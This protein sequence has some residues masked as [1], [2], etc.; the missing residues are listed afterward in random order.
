V[1]LSDIQGIVTSAGNIMSDIAAGRVERTVYRNLERL[2]LAQQKT[3]LQWLQDGNVG[4]DGGASPKPHGTFSWPSP[5]VVSI[6][7]AGPSDNYFFL[8]TLPVPT[9]AP[10]NFV[11]AF[12]NYQ[13]VPEDIGLCQ[14]LE[15]Q[16]EFKDGIFTYNM[17]W[18]ADCATKSM[19]IFDHIKKVWNPF[20]GIPFPD[21]SQPTRWSAEF[22]IDR[23][24]NTT[25]H[26]C[27]WLKGVRYL[28]NI[29]QPATPSSGAVELSTSFQIDA[30]GV[31]AA[32]TA[33]INNHSVAFL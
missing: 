33:E 1:S 15:C 11:L 6:K 7:P 13:V 4:N 12:D 30:N 24:A 19:R 27:L 5:N 23:I 31:G 16:N 28:V 18:Q 22:H 21:L 20:P 9:V 10:R 2:P 32:Y 26:E 8:L 17:A 29:T 25:T 14:A 3:I